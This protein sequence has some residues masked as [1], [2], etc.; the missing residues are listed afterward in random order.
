[1]KHSSRETN[2]VA[3]LMANEG[4]KKYFFGRTTIVTVPPVFANKAFWA[5]ILGIIFS[6]KILDCNINSVEQNL[7][8]TSYTLKTM[9]LFPFSC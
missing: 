2:K 3:D 9:Y 7:G 4:A 1:M 5:D 6:R 8:G